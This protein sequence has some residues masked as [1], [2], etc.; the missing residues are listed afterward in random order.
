[1]N[2]KARI[3]RLERFFLQCRHC[4]E[5]LRCLSCHT[6]QENLNVDMES[7]STEQLIR[8]VNGESVFSVLGQPIPAQK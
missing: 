4:G 5:P 6:R 1:M 3:D 2:T 7:L 8:I